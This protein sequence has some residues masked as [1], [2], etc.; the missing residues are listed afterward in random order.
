M[1]TLNQILKNVKVEQINGNSEVLCSSIAIDSRKVEMLSMFIAV[2]GTQIDGHQFIDTAIEKGAIVI[3]CEKIPQNM[4][5]GVT[6]VKVGNT[7][8]IIGILATEFYDNPSRKLKL[9]GVTGTNGKTTTATLLYKLFRKLGYT[10]G[11]FSTVRNFINDKE[12]EATH[13]TPDPIQLNQMLAEMVKEEC[14]FCFMEVS[15]HAMD[16]QRTAGLEFAGGVFSNL[17][18]DH[19]DYHK[20]FDM[21]LKAKKMFFDNLPKNAFALVNVDDKNGKVMLQNTKADTYTY[22]LKTMANFKCKIIEEHLDGMQIGFENLEVWTNFIG[23]FNAYNLLA[24]YS[25]AILLGQQR[26]EILTILSELK[27]VDGRFEFIASKNDIIAIVDYAHT[28]DALVNVLSTLSDLRKG[29]AS[30]KYQGRKIITVVGAGGNRDK[31]KRPKMA[32]I[33]A[34]MSDKLILTSDN[35]RFEKPEDI[36]ADMEAGLDNDLSVK[37]LTIVN[38]SEA[39]KTACFMASPGDIILIAGKGHENYQDVN[40]VK[41]HFDDREEVRKYLS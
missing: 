7:Q 4:N 15:S 14:K 23:E 6:Y 38:R 10:S 18:H 41:H 35:P 26:E 13:T 20:T 36:L 19:L 12:Y 5:K 16:Q 24:V 40:G 33:S 2:S 34:E 32:R 17:T 27:P 31:T 8:N 9:V 30:N 3:V 37:T 39:I 1:K 22:A 11:L 28:P 29:M 21:Y 25:T